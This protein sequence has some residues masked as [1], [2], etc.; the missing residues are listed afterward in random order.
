MDESGEQKE[1]AAKILIS[2]LNL[3]IPTLLTK[4]IYFKKKDYRFWALCHKVLR[5]QW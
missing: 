1:A 2:F 4:P 5:E 3:T